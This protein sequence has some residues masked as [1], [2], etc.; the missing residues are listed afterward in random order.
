VF[1][2]GAYANYINSQ[3]NVVD[4]FWDNAVVQGFPAQPKLT[5]SRQGANVLITWTGSGTLQSTDSLNPIKWTD[6]TPA[7]TGNSYSVTPA[8]QIQRFFRL[9]Q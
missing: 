3:G 4:A 5:V 8:P 9:R 1:G 6:V 2:F 7:P